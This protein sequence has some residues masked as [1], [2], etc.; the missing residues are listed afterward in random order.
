MYIVTLNADMCH[1]NSIIRYIIHSYLKMIYL[2]HG[3][4]CQKY[5]IIA[6]VIILHS[7]E[8]PFTLGPA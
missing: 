8:T 1:L 4:H 5:N 2:D 3:G 7:T 6:R